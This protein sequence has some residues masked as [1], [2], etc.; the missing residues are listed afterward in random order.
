MNIKQR[1]C[2]AGKVVP[3]QGL[4]IVGIF[5]DLSTVKFFDSKYSYHCRHEKRVFVTILRNIAHKFVTTRHHFSFSVLKLQRVLAPS[6]VI[7]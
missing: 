4:M 6:M 1:S 2:Q 5:Y 7:H 3:D